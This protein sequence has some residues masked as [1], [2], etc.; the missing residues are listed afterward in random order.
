MQERISF[1][2]DP[3][4]L[5]NYSKFRNQA[6]NPIDV[7]NEETEDYFGNDNQQELYAPDIRDC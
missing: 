3:N 6:R 4:V 1:Y 7:I 5:E 2:R